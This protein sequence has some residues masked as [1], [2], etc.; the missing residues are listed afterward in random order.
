MLEP[1][2][3]SMLERSEPMSTASAESV[4]LQDVVEHHVLR[5][6]KHCGGN[7]LRT[8]EL[9]GISRSTLYRMLESSSQVDALR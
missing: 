5:V 8:A 6:L 1:H 9:L 2:H 3:L 7:K 4:R